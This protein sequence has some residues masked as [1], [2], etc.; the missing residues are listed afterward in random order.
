MSQPDPL[1][2]DAQVLQT[3]FGFMVTRTLSA[4]AE[5]SPAK[6]MDMNMLAMTEGGSERTASEF[7]ELC[8][9]SGL[10]LEEVYPTKS[11]VSVVEA[12]R[13]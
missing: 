1:P 3:L 7:H 11:P 9:S 10:R 13:A 4:V 5:L 6:F 8:E 2:P 12:V